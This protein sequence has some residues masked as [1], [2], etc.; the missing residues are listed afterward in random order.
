SVR[1]AGKS[2]LALRDRSAAASLFVSPGEA[3]PP[4]PTARWGGAPPWVM[5]LRPPAGA[6]QV[7][8]SARNP[9][10]LRH[11]GE[12]P[13]GPLQHLPQYCG[14]LR[15]LADNG[16]RFGTAPALGGRRGRALPSGNVFRSNLLS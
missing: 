4:G 13:R 11:R 15:Q 14:A 2:A 7:I 10:P 6:R 12:R 3:P 16:S 1:V 5:P 8:R 9:P